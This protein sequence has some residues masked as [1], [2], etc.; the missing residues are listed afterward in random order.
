MEWNSY[1]IIPVV[2]LILMIIVGV[3]VS[4]KQD[5]RA[6]FYVAGNKMNSGLLFSTIFSTV[7]G[8]NTYMGFSG[9]VYTSGFS[10][11]WMLVA[12]GSAY[13]VL[14][15]ISGKIRRIAQE[16]EVFT[17]PDIMALRY[18]NFVAYLT[19]LFSLVAL[20]GGAG[21]SILGIGVILNSI[22]GIDTTV[23]IL[24]TSVVTIV[25]TTFG[26]LM[27]VALT[28]W[29]Q[30]I[31]MVLGL[32]LVI[33]FGLQALSPDSSW[34]Y[35]TTHGHES[36]NRV[37]GDG[38]ISV[39]ESATFL[40]VLAWAITFLPL[41]TISQTQIQRV[42]SAKSVS[43]IQ[44]ISLLMVWF[45]ALFMAFGLALVGGIGKALIP[46][47]GNAETVFPMLAM[48]V[49]NPWIGMI[50]VTGILGACM[51]TVD[52]NLLG[53]GI[54]VTRDIYEKNNVRKGKEI[55]EKH[56]LLI[57]R[58]TLVIIG[59]L[60]T[61]AAV[62][63]PSIMEL[64]LMTQKI[65][66]G[67]T[68]IPI[69]LGLLW[70]KA[71]TNGAISG[72]LL[73]GGATVTCQIIGTAVDP[74][75]VGIIFSLAGTVG[76][77][78]LIREENAKGELFQ[79]KTVTNKDIIFL[80]IILIGYVSFLIGANFVNVWPVLIIVTLLGLTLGAVLLVIYILPKRRIES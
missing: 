37:L 72:M 7:V 5:T 19:T 56:T 43:T 46:D 31:I 9:M 62:L 47:M 2:Y 66:A 11:M 63:T 15:Y 70:R 10:V 41:N 58:W 65:F 23:A 61:V 40:M 55:N 16:F 44:R 6:D 24:I 28:D 78:L 75:I 54:H 52:S 60:S 35:A 8:A 27:G 64:L 73:G 51:S 25:Y 39:T 17:L 79:V 13:F 33:I 3:V 59:V 68:F 4:K 14:F 34:L 76:A 1:Y 32:V 12:A 50:I 67:A 74:V 30:S 77:S 71:N 38:F 21:G 48:E 20:V 45:V 49:I 69:M 53:A 57:T 18:S 22:L 80:S 42:Y 36:L 26:G 29:I